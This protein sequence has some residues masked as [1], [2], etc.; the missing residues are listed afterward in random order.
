MRHKCRN[1]ITYISK[2]MRHHS[3]ASGYDRLPDFVNAQ[4]I[5]PVSEWTLLN[6][7]IGR[8]LNFFVVRSG[9]QWYRRSSMLSELTA[10]CVWLNHNGHIFHYLYGENSYRYLGNL[11]FLSRRNFIVC[12][13]H[14]PPDKFQRVV[15]NYRHLAHID[16]LI[17]VS[18]SQTDFFSSLVG[19]HRV[20]FVPHGIDIDFFKPTVTKA[21]E[22]N[23]LRC[24]F[25]GKHLRDFQTLAK[26]ARLLSDTPFELKMVVPRAA[27]ILPYFNGL[28]KVKC[29]S[30]ISDKS[31]LKLYQESDVFVLPLLGATANNSLLEAMACGLPI[32]S[33]D[34]PGVRDYVDASCSLLTPKGDPKDLSQAILSLQNI[35]RRIAMGVAARNR[36]LRFSWH[37]VANQVLSIYEYLQSRQTCER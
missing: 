17:V 5:H 31:L 16:A 4:V 36:S 34:L 2:R 13:Y 25:V 20:F 26:C 15:W 9:L 12:T 14:T 7:V 32:V 8:V 29:Y 27:E 21:L 3:G 19:R 23:V 24:L 11:D 22:S 1:A 33:T 6:R 28:D 35:D 18:T 37:R 30:G 10:G